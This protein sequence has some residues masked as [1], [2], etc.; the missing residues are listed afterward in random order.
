MQKISRDFPSYYLTVTK[1]YA[2][3]LPSLQ[4]EGLG[5]G[6]LTFPHEIMHNETQRHSV[7]KKTLYLCISVFTP[8]RLDAISS[9]YTSGIYLVLDY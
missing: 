9:L 3:P 6:S 1:D 4:G 8:I 2:Q 5:V 7:S